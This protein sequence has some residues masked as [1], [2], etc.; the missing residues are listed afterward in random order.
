LLP[1]HSSDLSANAIHSF[2]FHSLAGLDALRHLDLRNNSISRLSF[3][4]SVGQLT[5]ANSLETL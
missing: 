3:S 4:S 1:I 2:G 5:M